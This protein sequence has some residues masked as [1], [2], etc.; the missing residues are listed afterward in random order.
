MLLPGTVL[1]ASPALVPA[2]IAPFPAAATLAG[3]LAGLALGVLATLAWRA[4]RPRAT[5][6]LPDASAVL[7]ALPCA[8]FLKDADGHYLAVN[9]AFERHYRC[10]REDVLGQTLAGTRALHGVDTDAL[11]RA[12]NHLHQSGEAVVCEVGH[13]GNDGA[14]VL[15]LRLHPLPGPE[16]IRAVLG[17]LADM[18]ELREAQR[19]TEAAT[20]TAGTFLSLVS[21]E[22]RTPIAGALGLVELLA[23]TPLDQ[24]QVHMLGMLEE[25]VEGLLEILGDILDFSRLQAGELQLDSGEF[26]LRALVDEVVAAAP[27]QAGD[28]GVRLYVRL[29]SGLAA[30]YRG[31]GGRLRQVLSWLLASALRAT[32]SGYVDVHAEVVA[33]DGPVHRL[34]LS[35]RDSGT[36]ASPPW[37]A[38]AA[39]PLGGDGA[40]PGGLALGLA[41]CRQLV[42]L[43]RGELVLSSVKGEGSLACFELDLPVERPLVPVPA[44]AGRIV[45]ACTRDPR[46]G[47]AL[48]QALAALGMQPVEAMPSG[49]DTLS[50]GDAGLFLVDAALVRDGRLPAGA[51]HVCLLDPDDPLPAPEGCVVLPV[52]PLLWRNV[53]R[54]CHAALDLPA[55]DTDDVPQDRRHPVRLLVA[56]DHPVNRAVISRQLQRLGYAHDVVGDGSEALRALAG[57]HYDLLVTDCHMPVLD[58][59]ALVRRIRADERAQDRPRLPVLALSAS[60]LPGHVR[61]CIEAGMDDFLAKPVQL[62]ALELK[63][64]RHLGVGAAAVTA[65]HPPASSAAADSA[66]WRQLALLMEAYGSLRQ[67][68]EIV[69]GLLET[70]RVDL[71][72]LDQAVARGDTAAQNALLHRIRGSLQLVG[73][74]PGAAAPVAADLPARRA[75]VLGHVRWL[76]ELLESLGPP[77]SVPAGRA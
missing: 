28:T 31:D 76:E 58:G 60:V 70:C 5:P 26:D 56:E 64:A 30:A 59:Y 39:E 40:R 57:I 46:T 47:H 35:L 54:A 74:P 22:V 62:H 71:A 23:H 20:H 27:A 42:G 32:A 1:A 6:S 48:A 24:E 14:R 34:R 29:D 72:A 15:R 3:F 38:G 36:G 10:Q 2:V 12:E 43:M 44:L 67:V 66:A 17:I 68:R 63:L 37:L 75:A 9:R 69:Q 50:A 61:K 8:A 77:G 11:L 19:A 33:A 65:L 73:E 18:S 49:V 7:E 52:A 55:P 53:V 45:L 16:G 21:H 25:S 4:L 41:I 51:R 13:D